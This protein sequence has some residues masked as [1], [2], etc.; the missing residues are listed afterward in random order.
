[1]GI[2]LKILRASAQKINLKRH[3]FSFQEW[4]IYIHQR[5]TSVC[6]IAT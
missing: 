2:T 1:M 3:P 5:K 6:Q 4:E